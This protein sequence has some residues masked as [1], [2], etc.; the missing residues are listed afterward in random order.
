M[1]RNGGIYTSWSR[2]AHRCAFGYIL[3]P[4]G[5][6]SPDVLEEGVISTAENFKSDGFTGQTRPH[7][8]KHA[9]FILPFRKHEGKRLGE[10]PQQILT[11]AERPGCSKEKFS[12][13]H[14]LVGSGCKLFTQG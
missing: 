11:M 4:R 13:R 14:S 9:D 2:Q 8:N 6:L 10:V 12:P 7:A 5:G 1:D 3:M